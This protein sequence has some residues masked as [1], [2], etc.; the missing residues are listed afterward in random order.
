[1]SNAIISRAISRA[2]DEQI[3]SLKERITEKNEKLCA[4]FDK[5]ATT[6]QLIEGINHIERVA[7]IGVKSV[8]D[9][10]ITTISPDDRSAMGKI[11]AILDFKHEATRKIKASYREMRRKISTM[12]VVEREFA[13][14]IF[15]AF[16]DALG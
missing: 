9:F 13:D 2:I 12:N 7:I 6:D 5:G 15:D 4:E 10:V 16:A 3:G 8:S 11:S 1:M 14:M